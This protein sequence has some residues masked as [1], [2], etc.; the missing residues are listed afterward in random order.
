MH[1][2]HK[3]ERR[4]SFESRYRDIFL[5]WTTITLQRCINPR[6]FAF[7]WLGVTVADSTYYWH[8]LYQRYA[9]MGALQSYSVI[10]IDVFRVLTGFIFYELPRA[11]T[12][13]IL[14]PIIGLCAVSL[15][16]LLEMY[17]YRKMSRLVELSW[18]DQDISLFGADEQWVVGTDKVKSW[19]ENR[20]QIWF[21][22]ST[23][24]TLP[25]SIFT[26]DQ[27][28]DFKALLF[29]T[30]GATGRNRPSLRD[31]FR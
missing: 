1:G 24:F 6:T 25:K 13:S 10:A 20:N 31:I 27:L 30:T 22:A 19:S 26:D 29:K 8:I 9:E 28:T 11:L 23:Q 5:A 12:L 2:P 14:V 18:N 17:R 16:K 4:L 7:F 21:L 15:P 3:M